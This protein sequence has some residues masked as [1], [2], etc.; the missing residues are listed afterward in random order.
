MK[1]AKGIWLRC[2]L[3]PYRLRG[4]QLALALLLRDKPRTAA[5]LAAALTEKGYP[6]DSQ[7]LEKSLPACQSV[8]SSRSPTAS[9]AARPLSWTLPPTRKTSCSTSSA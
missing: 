1:C 7:M 8:V 5:Q 3:L 9:T 6:C 4:Q 2:G